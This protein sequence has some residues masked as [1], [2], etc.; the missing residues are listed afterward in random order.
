MTRIASRMSFCPSCAVLCSASQARQRRERDLDRR[1]D[2]G[3]GGG[4]LWSNA[5][6]AYKRRQQQYARELQEQVQ[7]KKVGLS[8]PVVLSGCLARSDP[9][10]ARNAVAACRLRRRTCEPRQSRASG[11]V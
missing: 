11:P 9:L 5:A 4:S 7:L 1:D 8:A 6:D 3:G 2:G 10:C